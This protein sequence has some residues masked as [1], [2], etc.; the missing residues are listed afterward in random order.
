MFEFLK[1]VLLVCKW[2]AQILQAVKIKSVARKLHK[3]KYDLFRYE[4]LIGNNKFL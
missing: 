2:E 4:H 1:H 3:G